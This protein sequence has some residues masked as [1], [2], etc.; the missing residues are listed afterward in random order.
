MPTVTC[1]NNCE[2]ELPVVK[3]SEC[4]PKIILS[5]IRKIFLG[6]KGTQPFND[7]KD[8]SEW[9]ERLNETAVTANT[10]RPLTVIADKK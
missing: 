6:K 3:F 7:W 9:T 2:S 1:P 5:E 10:I 8:A 4:S